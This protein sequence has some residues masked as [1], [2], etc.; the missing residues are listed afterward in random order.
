MDA[1]GRRPIRWYHVVGWLA[2]GALALMV[3]CCA[4]NLLWLK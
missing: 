3:R 1:T 2:I 4:F